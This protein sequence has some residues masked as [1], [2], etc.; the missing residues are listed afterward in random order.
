MF[1]VSCI[2]AGGDYCKVISGDELKLQLHA[3]VHY[4]VPVVVGMPRSA[5]AESWRHHRR[6]WELEAAA[7]RRVISRAMVESARVEAMW[8][9]QGGTGGDDEQS[10][11]RGRVAAA[12]ERAIVHDLVAELLTDLLA[13]PGHGRAGCRK[14]LCF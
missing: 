10:R 8:L 7:A 2:H 6:G 3:A 14:R 1:L 13:Q 9:A 4:P 11:E 12:L 5:G